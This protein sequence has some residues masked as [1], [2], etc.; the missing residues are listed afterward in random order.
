VR[1]V[2]VDA[3]KYFDEQAPWALRKTDPARMATVL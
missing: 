3:N 2:V 1:D